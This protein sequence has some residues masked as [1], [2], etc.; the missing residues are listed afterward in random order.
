MLSYLSPLHS[1]EIFFKDT[2]PLERHIINWTEVKVQATKSYFPLGE[3]Y[4]SYGYVLIYFFSSY[5]LFFPFLCLFPFSLFF[6]FYLV[7]WQ[8]LILLWQVY[9]PTATERALTI[10]RN[11]Y[12]GIHTHMD[13]NINFCNNIWRVFFLYVSWSQLTVYAIIQLL[14]LKYSGLYKSLTIT[15]WKP[16]WLT[17]NTS[18]VWIK[19][20]E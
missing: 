2:G 11:E 3:I 7:Y 10:W 20:S 15:V 16:S 4:N 9:I 19:S 1:N 18:P 6:W 5:L 12:L 17:I 8:W 14:A 13:V